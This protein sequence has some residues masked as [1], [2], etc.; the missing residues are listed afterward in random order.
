MNDAITFLN[1]YCAFDDP[2]CVWIMKGISRTKDNEN[3]PD[4]HQ[5]LRRMV[6]TS[7]EDI[8]KCYDEI[9]LVANDPKT[10][11]RIYISLNS[12]DAVDAAFQFQ[13]K[14]V[15]ITQGLAKRH[16]DALALSKKIGSLWKTELEQ[17]HARGTKR[18]L[19]DIDVIDEMIAKD[20][21]RYLQDKAKATIRAFRKTPNGFAIVFDA[22]DTRGLI[23]YYE[24]RHIDCSLQRDS[25]LFVE[26]F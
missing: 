19:L 2:N 17:K 24:E 16:D 8:Q 21:L 10:T 25:M 13:K 18:L 6:L 11:Y 14:L 26:Q 3:S 9:H 12:R 7:P 23:K 5:F 4:M 22:C 1:D 15:D 20:L